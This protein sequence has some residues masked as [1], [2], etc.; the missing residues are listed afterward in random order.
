MLKNDIPLCSRQKAWAWRDAQETITWQE[1]SWLRRRCPSRARGSE[2]SG[3]RRQGKARG[4]LG[5]GASAWSRDQPSVSQPCLQSQASGPMRSGLVA[6]TLSRPV[7]FERSSLIRKV[8]FAVKR[9][10]ALQT[11]KPRLSSCRRTPQAWTSFHCASTKWNAGT[12]A[13]KRNPSTA[14]SEV[15]RGRLTEGAHL[16]PG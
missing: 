3:R 10:Y 11:V 4:G 14:T 8:P 6:T 9:S 12:Q 1:A 7:F 15:S 13:A 16:A 5:S 2:Q